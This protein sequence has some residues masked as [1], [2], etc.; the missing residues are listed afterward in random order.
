VAKSA[1]TESV[2]GSASRIDRIP[3]EIGARRRSMNQVLV[4][5]SV[6][7]GLLTMFVCLWVLNRE[8]KPGA[9]IRPQQGMC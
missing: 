4:Y 8:P 5:L 7:A 2:T 1:V 6:N 9:A 3:D